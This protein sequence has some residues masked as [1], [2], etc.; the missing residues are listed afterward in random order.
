MLPFSRRTLLSTAIATPALL[1]TTSENTR[2]LK[3]VVT[4]GHPGDPE[5]GCG[6]TVARFTD[7]GHVV[8][9]LYLNS[10]QKVCPDIKDDPG[11]TV[12]TKEA[13]HACT[14][15][16]AN[17]VF[18]GQCDGHAVVDE[19]HY[20]E[21]GTM[22]ETLSPDLVFTQWPLDGHRD[23]RATFMLVY[24]A[25]LRTK[26]KFALFFYEVSNGEDTQMF[27]PTKYV[28]ISATEP[29]KRAACYAHASQTPDRY[30]ALQSQVASFRGIES[31]YRQAE[32]FVEHVGGPRV[33]LP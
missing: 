21:F 28:D 30:Y 5:Y 26:K 7:L 15:L 13:Q 2:S 22:L 23:H 24:D 14:I 4:G 1:S 10:G 27:S 25:W 9:L 17:P 33:L 20:R 8:T 18:A 19:P 32:A 3:I 16:K 6:G 12:R 29:Q 31:G 11:S